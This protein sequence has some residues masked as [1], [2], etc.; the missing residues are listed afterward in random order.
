MQET[1]Q[2]RLRKIPI[3]TVRQLK[4]IAYLQG[5]T[6]E[7]YITELLVSLHNKK[8]SKHGKERT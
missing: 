6:M 1:Q 7:D 4:S 2:I 5:K 3:K 8:R